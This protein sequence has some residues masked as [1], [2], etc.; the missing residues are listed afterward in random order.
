MRDDI[1]SEDGLQT[2]G[3]RVQRVERERP[4]VDREVP[5][6]RHQT[7]RVLAPAVH[8]WLD[9]ELPETAVPQGEAQ[10]DVDFW[11]LINRVTDD[12]RLVRTPANLEQ[13][14]MA[15]LPPTLP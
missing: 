2:D 15:A 14:I 9:G 8:A 1:H 12:R 3:R 6:D 10:R 4:L 7:P 13:R 5:L 11:K